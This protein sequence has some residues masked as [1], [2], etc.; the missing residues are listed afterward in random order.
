MQSLFPCYNVY[1]NIKG[2][3]KTTLLDYPGH[4]AATI[5]LGG[6]NFRC[7][8]CHNMNLV[9]NTEADVSKEE[10]MRFLNKRQ[11][12]IDGV[13]ITGG[14]PTLYNDLPEFIKEIKDI[15]Y[16]IKL[17]T[18]GTNPDMIKTLAEKNLIDYIAMDIKTRILDYSVVSGVSCDD[19]LICKIKESVKFLINGSIDYEF[20]TTIIKNYHSEDV[21]KEISS[22]IQ[23]A[24]RYFLQNYI[25]S[26]FVQDKSLV[27]CTLD[28]LNKYKEML[29]KSGINTEI[30]GVS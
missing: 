27:A 13:C 1:M 30:R 10:I 9:I 24:K 26:E 7:P 23:G 11:G 16:L 18:N 15:G 25:E 14:E 20:R 6:C 19:D 8:F 22:E 2:L 29:K 4:V 17:D 21:M 28:E 3:Q 12:I 5:F